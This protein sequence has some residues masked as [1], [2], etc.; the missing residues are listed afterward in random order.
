MLASDMK[1]MQSPHDVVENADLLLCA[2]NS[3]QPVFD[4][5]W[6]APGVHVNAIG[7]KLTS[8]HELPR[9]I[10]NVATCVV[11]DSLEQLGAYPEPH[12]LT[13]TRAGMLDLSDLIVGNVAGRRGTEDITLFCSTGL[14]GT[15]VAVAKLFLGAARGRD[16]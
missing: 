12:I 16:V 13:G 3:A 4:A 9:E 15:E 6:L 11:T 1:A 10:G 14:A 5:A 7:P 8:R 2:T